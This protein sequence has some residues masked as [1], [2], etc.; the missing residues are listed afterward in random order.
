MLQVHASV[1]LFPFSWGLVNLGY[2]MIYAMRIKLNHKMSDA[3]LHE[4][5][6]PGW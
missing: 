4:D 1:L 6:E 2:T 3:K 5:Q